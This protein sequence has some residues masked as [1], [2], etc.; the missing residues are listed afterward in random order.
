MLTPPLWALSRILLCMLAVFRLH[1]LNRRKI[2]QCE[3]EGITAEKADVFAELGDASPLYRCVLHPLEI[4]PVRHNNL[5][6]QVHTLKVDWLGV[7]DT[8]DTLGYYNSRHRI[9][10]ATPRDLFLFPHSTILFPLAVIW[11]L[12]SP[13]CGPCRIRGP[14]HHVHRPAVS[15][16]QLEVWSPPTPIELLLA[17][18]LC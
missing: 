17:V 14:L 8:S 4:A 11:R 16:F 3:R 15:R 7:A 12:E 18:H 1:T 5:Y 6:S 10:R 13:T 9:E 2:A